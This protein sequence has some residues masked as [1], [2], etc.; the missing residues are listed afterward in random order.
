MNQ[1]A[2][3]RFETASSAPCAAPMRLYEDPLDADDCNDVAVTTSRRG[4]TRLAL[5]AAET[6][7]TLLVLHRFPGRTDALGLQDARTYLATGAQGT[8]R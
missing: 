2:L 3:T 4:L 1:I 7:A 6:G 8:K 5:V